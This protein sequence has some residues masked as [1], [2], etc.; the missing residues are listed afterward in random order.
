LNSPH[1]SLGSPVSSVP[2]LV[3]HLIFLFQKESTRNLS[4]IFVDIGEIR[5]NKNWEFADLADL[6]D[7]FDEIGNEHRGVHKV[8]SRDKNF[9][10][11]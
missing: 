3:F 1:P 5:R 6:V 4:T 2:A 9:P 7:S 8:R 11:E 10:S